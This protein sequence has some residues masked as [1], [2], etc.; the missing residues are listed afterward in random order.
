MP[1]I[2]I[3]ENNGS[4]KEVSVRSIDASEIYKKAG[5]K[6]ADGFAVRATWNV[7]LGDKLY[8]ISLYGKIAGRAGQENKYEFPPPVDNTLF[9]GKCVLVNNDSDITVAEW[10]HVYEHLFGGFDDIGTEDSEEEDEEFDDD[11]ELTKS[12]YMK[13]D[14]VVEDDDEEEDEEEEDEEEDFSD[15]SDD[16]IKK[17]KKKIIKSI[18]PKKI[19]IKKSKVLHNKASSISQ[20]AYLDCTSELIEEDYV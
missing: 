16:D 13:D 18:K 17:K 8:D 4:L 12:G 19:P 15:A 9:F 5:F 6:I 11:A 1:S 3:V 14:F 7:T 20:S 10:K 2:I